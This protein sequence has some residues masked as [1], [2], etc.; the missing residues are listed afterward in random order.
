[1]YSIWG[2]YRTDFAE[3]AWKDRFKV[4]QFNGEKANVESFRGHEVP[5]NREGV[6]VI[7]SSGGA[8]EWSVGGG[9][10]TPDDFPVGGPVAIHVTHSGTA[11]GVYDTDTLAGRAIWGG[12]Y[13]YFGSTAEPFLTS[14]QPS[15]YFAPRLANGAPFSA[16]FRQRSAQN[17]YLPWRLMIVGDPLFCLREKAP[18]RKPLDLEKTPLAGAEDVTGANAAAFGDAAAGLPTWKARLRRARWCGDRAAAAAVLKQWPKE[19]AP[20]GEALA[21][22]LEEDVLA[23]DAA[24]A[25]ARWA[26]ASDEA[27]KTYAARIYARYGSA[28][29][30]DKALEAKDFAQVLAHFTAMLTTGPARNFTDRW[31]D[32]AVAL[33]FEKKEEAA[34][35]AWLNDRSADAALADFK[36]AFAVRIGRLKNDALY[37]KEKWT[38]EDKKEAF[39]NLTELLK[40][41][42]DANKVAAAVE[43]LGDACQAKLEKASSETFAK[44]VAALFAEESEQ[45]K[46][47]KAA[48][49]TYASKRTLFKDW[50][51][52][53]A[54]TAQEAGAPDKVAPQGKPDFAA[55]FKDGD[56]ELKWARLFKPED[57]GIVD[58]AAALKPNENCFAY[59]A[60]ALKVEKDAEGTL[61]IGSDD[62]VTVWLDGKEIHKN[63]AARGVK[64]D[65]DRVRVKLAAGT[66][67]L[68]LRVDQG[69][70]GWGF[71]LRVADK[72]GKG[73][74]AGVTL[75]C[76]ETK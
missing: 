25:E 15:R 33:A 51:F 3:A 7:N 58:L 13:W 54:F 44:D 62:G 31:L 73:A 64:I 72:A 48:L 8:H 45:G 40:A 1:P 65:E 67:T 4:T 56:R 12:A 61:M 71:C 6:I 11:A 36:G 50:L 46:A 29:L 35:M 23:G 55:A 42:K 57:S 63:P 75:A 22:L 27:K 32:K 69:G 38:D 21:M 18:E 41:E 53:G 34:C 76:P 19:A 60:A 2:Y 28:S 14:F 59:A 26:A 24:G 17:F 30:M 70:G 16:T 68:L 9:G 74:L 39:A 47:L 5:W 10:G 37:K 52:L 66:H 43:A 20:D 49:E